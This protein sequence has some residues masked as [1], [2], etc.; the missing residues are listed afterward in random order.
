MLK[1]QKLF[2]L[3]I[4][5]LLYVYGLPVNAADTSLEQWTGKH[6]RLVWVQD[7][8]NGADTF[9]RGTNLQLYGY[10]SRDG[11]GERPL[12]PVTGNFFKPLFT[13][14]GDSVIVSDRR[15]RQMFLIDWHNGAVKNLGSGVAVAV[16]EDPEPSLILRKK[17][18]WVYS[19]SGL[20][21]ENKYGTSQP[22]YR[23]PLDKPKQKELV[24][25]KTNM[26]WSSLQLSRDGE[27]IGGLF[28][29]PDGGVLF[30]D[31]GVFRRLGKGC[32]TSLSPDNSKL[33]WIFDGLHRNVQIHDVMGGGSW[34]VNINGAPGINGFEVYH[35]RWSN[36]PRYFVLTGPYEKGDGGNRIGGGGEK[37]EVFIGRFDAA[38]RSVEEWFQLTHNNRADF[39]PD[40][41]LEGG[42]EVD[43]EAAEPVAATSSSAESW[44]VARD[45]LVFLWENMKA[46]NQLSEASPLGFLQCNLELRGR[47]LYSK[48]YQLLAGGGWGEAG[49]VG[50][51][52][53]EALAASK[54]ATFTITVTTEK[55]QRGILL[56]FVN[57][58]KDGLQIM[59]QD[60]NL[61]VNLDQQGDGTLLSWQKVFTP[62]VPQSLAV[63]LDGS[64]VEFFIGGRSL[65]RKKAGIDFGKA[66]LSDFIVGDPSGDWRGS[67]EGLAVYNQ[68]LS[69]AE[70]GRN[71][72]LMQ[73]ALETRKPLQTLQ[74]KA[75]LA[76]LTEIP[77]PDS[78]GAYSR[79]LV[80][81][82]YK[83]KDVVEGEYQEQKVLVAEWAVLDRQIIK[84]Y[85]DSPQ[86]ELLVL[87]KFDEHPQLEGERQMMDIFEPDLEMYYRLPT[88]TN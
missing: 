67:L 50:K 21:P 82:S 81:N 76:E 25:N 58:G 34:K 52:I 9:A 79:A 27:I 53:G 40:L 20:Q 30:S 15:S 56:S 69:A 80:I 84:E 38:A 37:V 2:R 49:E 70:I 57:G 72:Q 14:D 43:L 87:Q 47:A 85:S 68:V 10:D 19:F 54:K 17:T 51:K 12:L 78:I 28:P 86:T 32:W 39:Y 71:A 22:L 23:F 41:W 88:D 45:N 4:L 6:T 1:N 42:D 83:V 65:G 36:H 3:F 75:E 11:R 63:T 18:V 74:V 29:W 24:W 77:A 46:A 5:L 44:P 31:S 8:G 60:R 64:T 55:E 48:D 66:M 35:P 62:G 61:L 59:Q 7:H 26:A 33:L 73:Q 13:P 16:W